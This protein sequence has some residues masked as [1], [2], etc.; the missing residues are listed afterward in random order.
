MEKNVDVSRDIARARLKKEALSRTCELAHAQ[1]SSVFS[2]TLQWKDVEEHL[3]KTM[4]Y[5]E[6]RNVELDKKTKMLDEREWVVDLREREFNF[7]CNR[8]EECNMK[9]EAKVRELRSVEKSIELCGL[10]LKAKQEELVAVRVKI[11]ECG[12]EVEKRRDELDELQRTLLSLSR[13]LDG[14]KDELSLVEDSVEKLMWEK[15][16]LQ[17]EIS[18]CDEQ[19]DA[20]QKELV[21]VRMKIDE[22]G[23]DFEKRRNELDE[24]DEL[25]SS[26]LSCT[27]EL[28]SKKDELRLVEDSVEKIMSEKETLHNVI[29]ECDEELELKMIQLSE[30]ERLTEVRKKEFAL[31]ADSYKRL[32]R[33][34][35]EK[36]GAKDY[37][38]GKT[39]E[40]IEVCKRKL[41]AK[42]KKL[43]LT[44]INALSEDTNEQGQELSTQT[45]QPNSVQEIQEQS[46]DGPEVTEELT[47]SLAKCFE[48]FGSEKG[49]L[50]E[51]PDQDLSKELELVFIKTVTDQY[52]KELREKE[53]HF[54]SIKKSLTEHMQDLEVFEERVKELETKERESQKTIEEQHQ[55]LQMQET[56]LSSIHHWQIRNEQAASS[57]A[58]ECVNLLHSLLETCIVDGEKMLWLLMNENLKRNGSSSLEIFNAIKKAP[59]PAK[60]VLDTLHGFFPAYLQH[61]DNE[62]DVIKRNC[63][64]LLEHLWSFSPQITPQVQYDALKLAGE[65]KMNM[66]VAENHSLE[67]L[68]FLLLVA[69]F[70]LATELDRNELP[71]LL[72]IA[73]PHKQKPELICALGIETESPGKLFLIKTSIIGIA[74]VGFSKAYIC[75]YKITHL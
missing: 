5:V 67:V 56:Q 11:G 51:L 66:I 43:K 34:L 41:E 6:E 30:T 10:E 26:V 39:D 17:N 29:R 59:D 24:L 58:N 62:I 61:K 36:I 64:Q 23:S 14:K 12:S 57:E 7:V 50:E 71:K 48:R 54:D 27:R 33:Q 74:I 72:A 31:K 19:V 42:R 75:Y 9:L 32:V 37:V 63:I 53:E 52:L 25:E 45:T 49:H 46:T 15:E 1:A 2:F 16:T 73:D 69:A 55:K 70:G 20:K 60:L 21:R 68:G 8:I 35:K 3:E 18:K 65:W 40:S 4:R 44:G 38:V 13:E 28:N 22:C 47:A